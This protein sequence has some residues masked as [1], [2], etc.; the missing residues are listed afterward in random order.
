MKVL[1]GSR[2]SLTTVSNGRAAIARG[3]EEI[4]YV[5]YRVGHPA[6]G[7]LTIGDIELV[8]GQRGWGYGSEAVRL[9]EGW[10]VYEGLAQEFR[11]EVDARN[12]L[13]LYFWLRLGYR[14]GASAGDGR[15]VMTMVRE[16]ETGDR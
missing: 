1:F 3:E 8:E 2:V 6:E 16:I 5:E 15:D 12:G 4:G 14:P 11:A 9:L 10:A 13:G 7:W